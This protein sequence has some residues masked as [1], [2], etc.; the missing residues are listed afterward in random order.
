MSFSTTMDLPTLLDGCRIKAGPFCGSYVTA[1]GGVLTWYFANLGLV[2]FVSLEDPTV[3]GYVRKH[4]DNYLR[5]L[6]SP[7]M[8]VTDLVIGADGSVEGYQ[9]VDADDSTAASFLTLACTY[10]KVSGGEDWFSI[11]MDTFKQ[12]AQRN[13]IQNRVLN[14]GLCT[15]Y[16]C[17]T[18][19]PFA[20]L[21][22]NCE[23]Y[24]GLRD[25]A[26]YLMQYG[27]PDAG[28]YDQYALESQAGVL[29]MFGHEAGKWSGDMSLDGT[30]PPNDVTKFEPDGTGQLFPTAFDLG[31]SLASQ[32]AGNAYLSQ[33]WSGWPTTNLTCDVD[34]GYP[35]LIL[36]YG[37]ALLGHSDDTTAQLRRAEGMA[38]QW[39]SI[40]ELGWCKRILMLG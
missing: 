28:Q 27:L 10:A 12:V 34:P 31:A 21:E 30:F 37:S 25:L 16:Q 19:Y 1:P 15:G 11:N 7:T 22:D 24:R 8:T 9:Q 38:P 3:L 18:E 5:H 13:L 23:V 33:K 36:G 35:W 6:C 2:P 40:N 20:Q 17:K 39:L 4:L 26:D 14:T 32:Q 29:S